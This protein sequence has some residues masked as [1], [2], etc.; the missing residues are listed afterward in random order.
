MNSRYTPVKRNDIDNQLFT[1]NWPAVITQ[2]VNTITQSSV[3]DYTQSVRSVAFVTLVIEHCLTAFFDV[4]NHQHSLISVTAFS[5]VVSQIS[6]SVRGYLNRVSRFQIHVHASC[7]HD[8][9]SNPYTCIRWMRS[10]I[11]YLKLLITRSILP[12]P[13]DFEIKRVA[14]SICCWGFVSYLVTHLV[15]TAKQEGLYLTWSHT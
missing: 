12:G 5:K 6:N 7:G 13:L 2:I 8:G 11:G 4:S 15:S 14:C 3:F 10:Q 9:L 1:F